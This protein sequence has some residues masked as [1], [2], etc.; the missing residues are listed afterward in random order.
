MPQITKRYDIGF[1]GYNNP[2]RQA[3]VNIIKD[4]MRF[5]HFDSTWEMHAARCMNELKIGL[6]I[7]VEDD[8]LNMR[9]FET[10]SVGIP[11]L[12]NKVVGNGMEDF[13]EEDRDYLA[14][15]NEQELKEKAVRLIASPD[16]RRVV[17]ESA[18]TKVLAM[19]T[20]RNRLNTV[21]ATLGYDMLK[22]V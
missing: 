18:R 15:S 11:L 9:T 16:M 14:F 13:F 20:Y 21:L 22:N 1:V 4:Y 3:Y 8:V 10:M 12:I 6:N 2:K 5:K 7:S 17:S 19:H